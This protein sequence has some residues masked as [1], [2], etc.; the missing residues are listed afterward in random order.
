MAT[1]PYRG[2]QPSSSSPGVFHEA[3]TGAIVFTPENRPRV[4]HAETD[5]TVTL[6]DDAGTEATYTILA[7]DELRFSPAEVVAVT[8]TLYGW[9]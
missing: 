2:W 6:K 3:I 4:L 5:C 1:K 9:R 7:G 8:G